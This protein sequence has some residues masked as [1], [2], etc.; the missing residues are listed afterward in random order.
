[1]YTR[2]LA[3]VCCAL[4]LTVPSFSQSS[5]IS[6]QGFAWDDANG[7]G[8]FAETES[9]LEG[10][11]VYLDANNNQVFDEGEDSQSTDAS[12]TFVFRDLAAGSYTARLDH[13]S[14]WGIA[15]PFSG[16]YVFTL[17]EGE[18]Q[19]FVDFGVSR[20]APTP[21]GDFVWLDTN[22]NGVQNANEQGIGGIPLYLMHA[23]SDQIVDSTTT[24]DAGRFTLNTQISGP[25]FIAAFPP[26]SYTPTPPN[27]G[28]KVADSDLD[29]TRPFMSFLRMSA[30][31]L[32]RDA[33]VLFFL[34]AC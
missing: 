7:D 33:C 6:V 9:L 12:G 30:K 32:C 31:V 27:E 11:T 14:D 10:W 2:L 22:E 21:I 16:A 29:P 34:P 13:T 25:Y 5:S 26:D 24:D 28:D 20:L 17:A 23:R 19:D 1:M 4:F 3:L 8:D 15:H 18:M